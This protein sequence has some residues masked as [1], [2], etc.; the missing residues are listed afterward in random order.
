LPFPFTHLR[1][2]LAK[3]YAFNKQ[4]CELDW[5]IHKMTVGT[6]DTNRPMFEQSIILLFKD[7]FIPVLKAGQLSHYSDWAWGWTTKESGPDSQE[8]QEFFWYSKREKGSAAHPS[9]SRIS[10]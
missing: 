1:H 2:N 9:L 5:A 7:S 3:F 8:G 4:N 6:G 10:T